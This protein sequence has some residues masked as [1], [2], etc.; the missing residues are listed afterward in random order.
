MNNKSEHNKPSDGAFK[1]N[2][3]HSGKKK[4]NPIQCK[5]DLCIDDDIKQAS[6]GRD[7]KSCR[8]RW[9]LDCNQLRNQSLD[10]LG[11]CFSQ[12]GVARCNMGRDI[13][14]N[15]D[16]YKLIKPKRNS[17]A[18]T[19]DRSLFTPHKIMHDISNRTFERSK[20]FT[21]SWYENSSPLNFACSLNVRINKY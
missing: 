8:V 2:Y 6:T 11:G 5:A 19:H 18:N 10:L 13:R 1:G 9:I 3:L 12:P 7:F 21:G 17:S 20:P 16:N 14:N 15:I 4:K